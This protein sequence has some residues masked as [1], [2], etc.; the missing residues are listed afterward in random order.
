MKPSHLSTDLLSVSLTFLIQLWNYHVSQPEKASCSKET[1]QQT[2]GITGR[3]ERKHT[4]SC[5]SRGSSGH[6][7]IFCQK[8]RIYFGRHHSEPFSANSSSLK[9]RAS[10]LAQEKEEAVCLVSEKRDNDAELH[11]PGDLNWDI[12]CNQSEKSAWIAAECYRNVTAQTAIS[13]T[14][15]SALISQGVAVDGCCYVARAGWNNKT[16][17]PS[18]TTGAPPLHVIYESDL[19]WVCVT[20]CLWVRTAVSLSLLFKYLPF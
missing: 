4:N 7:H 6:M 12:I 17:L 3:K 10:A 2:G 15:G 13:G 16:L 8:S 20:S 18:E 11:Q 14:W 5:K 19:A 9:G 1:G